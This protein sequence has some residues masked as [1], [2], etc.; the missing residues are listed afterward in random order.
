MHMTDLSQATIYRLID[1]G[2][3]ATV[4]IG[5]RRLIPIEAIRS[6]S[7]R[8]REMIATGDLLKDIPRGKYRAI[9]I[10]PLEVGDGHQDSAATLSADER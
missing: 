5:R 3:L 9:V 4:K 7:A 1:A 2:K 6:P 8:A 10:D